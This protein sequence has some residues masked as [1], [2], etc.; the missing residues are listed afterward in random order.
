[1]ANVFLT[2]TTISEAVGPMGRQAMWQLKE[3]LQLAGWTPDGSGD[4]T[5]AYSATLDVITTHADWSIGGWIVLTMPG[6][7]RQIHFR[8]PSNGSFYC[9]YSYA[10]LYT[11]GGVATSPT[12]TDEKT[13]FGYGPPGTLGGE[14]SVVS[15]GG[16]DHVLN[17][18]AQNAAPYGFWMTIKHTL[19]LRGCD[20]EDKF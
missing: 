10:G 20:R 16:P 2:N 6:S 12:A 15:N 3:H 13:W 18:M 19:C 8:Q 14:R 9:G 17:I 11:G 1:M 7:P 5:G 4:G